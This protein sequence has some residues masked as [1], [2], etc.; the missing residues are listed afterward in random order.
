MEKKKGGVEDEAREEIEE[1]ETTGREENKEKEFRGMFILNAGREEEERGG[2]HV[3]DK[4][5]CVGSKPKEK[6]IKPQI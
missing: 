3:S 2:K 4:E 1:E 6:I 5:V